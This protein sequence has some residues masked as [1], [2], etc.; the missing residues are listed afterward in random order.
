MGNPGG[1]R[2]SSEWRGVVRRGLWGVCV[3]LAACSASGDLTRVATS[4]TVPPPFVSITTSVARLRAGRDSL[5]LAWA[6]GNVTSCVASGAWSGVQPS[7]SSTWIKPQSVGVLTYTLQCTGPGGT[8][9]ASATVETWVPLPVAPTSYG[10]F[11]EVGLTTTVIPGLLSPRAYGDF[12]QSGERLLFTADLTYSGEKPLELATPAVYGF[13]RMTEG[14]WRSAPGILTAATTRPCVHPRQA[15]VADF[16]NDGKPD[17][18]VACHGYDKP[19]F[20]GERNQ[21]ILSSPAGTYT[22]SDAAPDVGF[23]HGAAAADMNGDGTVDVVV[24]NGRD[25]V[26]F[27][28]DGLGHFSRAPGNLLA[29]MVPTA[30][31][32]TVQITDVDEDG[33]AD[34][35]IGGSDF[36]NTTCLGDPT[37]ANPA[38]PTV[39]LGIKGGGFSRAVRLPSVAGEGMVLDFVIT[40]TGGTRALWIDRTS[41]G[42][43]I[44]GYASRTVQ[45]VVWRTLESSVVFTS[46]EKW[47]PWLTPLNINGT[48]YIGTDQTKD[49]FVPLRVP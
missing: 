47:M 44:P 39:V 12:S 9:S 29:G 34:L 5:Q 31:W 15:L 42:V 8:S 22:L 1:L 40:G 46:A 11:K 20:P 6:A 2:T 21:V 4:T 45:R 28:N 13:S 10:N 7:E 32:W 48:W 30:G 17:V 25:V 36:V 24:A 38:A 16:N 3:V 18:F 27:A 41:S 23:W 49:N 26:L 35:I 14:F 37:C 33:V 43:N 19:P